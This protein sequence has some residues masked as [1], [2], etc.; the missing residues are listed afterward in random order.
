MSRLERTVGNPIT[1]ERVTFLK[2]PAETEGK[3]LLFRTHLPPRTGIFRHYHT[4]YTETFSDVSGVL[5]VSLDGKRFAMKMGDRQLIETHRT[6]GFQNTTAEP[7]EFTTRIEPPYTF[8]AFIRCGYG[9]DTDGRS[10]YMPF[11]RI[12]LPRNVLLWGP[13]FEL[14]GF[15]MPYVPRFLQKGVAAVLTML[16]SWTGVLKTLDKYYKEPA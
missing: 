3:Y 9:L 5:E 13:L 8:E 16:A 6:H 10:G 1:G 7:V 14:G 12:Y 11:L 4:A 15:Y 2:L